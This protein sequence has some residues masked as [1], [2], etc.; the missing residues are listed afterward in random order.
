MGRGLD[1]P[2]ISHV[3]IYDMGDVDDYVHRIGRTARGPQGEGH[4]LTLFEYDRKWPSIPGR[5]I[6]VLEQAGQNV[7]DELRDIAAGVTGH[8]GGG[9][10]KSKYGHANVMSEIAKTPKNAKQKAAAFNASMAF[11]APVMGKGGGWAWVPMW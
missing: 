3:V 5:L 8:G 7:P 4:A 10:T 6:E 11:G 1:I 9:F 2:D